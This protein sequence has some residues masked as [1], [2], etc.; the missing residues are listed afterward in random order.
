MRIWNSAE[1]WAYVYYMNLAYIPEDST[2]VSK[3]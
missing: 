3:N 1:N 2:T